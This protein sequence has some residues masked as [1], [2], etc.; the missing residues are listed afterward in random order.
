[1]TRTKYQHLQHPTAPRYKH[2]LFMMRS[3]CNM[4]RVSFM[5]DRRLPLCPKCAVAMVL[6]ETRPNQEVAE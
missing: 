2:D 1:M 3:A 6:H 5:Q 4:P